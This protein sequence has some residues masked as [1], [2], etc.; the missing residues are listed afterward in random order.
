[1][2]RAWVGSGIAPAG[3]ISR[4]VWTWGVENTWDRT[5]AGAGPVRPMAYS[6][7]HKVPGLLYRTA[8][9][10]LIPGRGIPYGFP[11]GVPYGLPY[12]LL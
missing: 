9:Y 7:S 2:N 5:L 11:Y 6:R 4:V 8:S 10:S 12:G 3:I 1:M